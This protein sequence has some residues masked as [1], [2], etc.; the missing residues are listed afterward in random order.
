MHAFNPADAY[1]RLVQ[2][3][4]HGDLVAVDELIASGARHLY[5]TVTLRGAAPHICV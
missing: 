1:G 3:A 5:F 4:Y 2:E